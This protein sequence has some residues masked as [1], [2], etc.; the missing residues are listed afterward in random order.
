MQSLGTRPTEVV[1]TLEQRIKTR[2]DGEL[3]QR[4]RAGELRIAD[5]GLGLFDQDGSDGTCYLT[6]DDVARVAAAAA[7]GWF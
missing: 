7:R 5:R 3:E 2:L 4:A 1:E 6:L